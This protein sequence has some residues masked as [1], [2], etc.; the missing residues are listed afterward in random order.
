MSAQQPATPMQ[1][2][3][4]GA[5]AAAF[6]LW[7]VLVGLGVLPVPGGPRNLHGPL[8]IVL[9]AGLAFFLAG[10]AV[11]IQVL[12]HANDSGEFPPDAPFWMRV[13]QYLIFVAIFACFALIGS[14]VAFGPGPRGFSGSFMFFGHA[15]NEWIGR[16]VFGFGA[17]LCWLGTLAAAVVGGRKLFGRG[18]S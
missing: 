13:V 12:G 15:T 14:W 17:V 2:R 8:W 11:L 16:A 9:A 18:K 5:G 10:A 6:G 3:W 7:L 4:I 1:M